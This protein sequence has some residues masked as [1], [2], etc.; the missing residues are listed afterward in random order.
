VAILA[1]AER[2]SGYKVFITVS[3]FKVCGCLSTLVLTG[4]TK[5]D[6]HFA[7]FTDKE[8]EKKQRLAI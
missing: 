8:L 1:K 4:A 3:I 5:E 6:Y 7:N 2:L